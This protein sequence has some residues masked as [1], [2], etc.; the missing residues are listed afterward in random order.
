MQLQIPLYPQKHCRLILPAVHINLIIRFDHEQ[1]INRTY[2]LMTNMM[3][4][5]FNLKHENISG[6]HE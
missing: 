3:M 4:G 2:L 5:S 6:L 1:E